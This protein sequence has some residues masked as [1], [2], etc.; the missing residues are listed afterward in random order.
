M[1]WPSAKGLYKYTERREIWI[2]RLADALSLR[3]FGTA[4][5]EGKFDHVH[6]YAIIRPTL[7]NEED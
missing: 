5:V 3:A 6:I 2:G 4:V 7:K 1:I